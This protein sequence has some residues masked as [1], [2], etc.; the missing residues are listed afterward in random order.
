MTGHNELENMEKMA[1]IGGISL[2]K[3]V[4]MEEFFEVVLGI[5]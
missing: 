4:D 2:I 3:P 1:Q 5:L